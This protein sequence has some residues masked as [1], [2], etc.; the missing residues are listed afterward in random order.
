MSIDSPLAAVKAAV[1]DLSAVAVIDIGCGSGAFAGQLAAAGARAVGIDPNPE[2]IEAAARAA[3]DARFVIAGAQALPFEAGSFDL[4]VFVNSLHHVPTELMAQALNEAA[5]VTRPGGRVVVVEP[6]ATGSFCE[7]VRL[8]DDETEVR[9]AAQLALGQAVE[10][11][12]FRLVGSH[13]YDRIDRFSSVDEF[14]ELIVAVDPARRADAA[15]RR[16]EIA[17]AYARHGRAVAGGSEFVQPIKVD[18]LAI[19]AN[20]ST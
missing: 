5:R 18:I 16:D 1:P 8:V 13:T 2:A 4:A 10:G 19:N 3:P 15:A 17:A 7:I 9:A 6:L 14:V 12:L 11:G 20:S